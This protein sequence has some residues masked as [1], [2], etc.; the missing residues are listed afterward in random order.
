MEDVRNKGLRGATSTKTQFANF[1]RTQPGYYGEM[2]SGI[3]LQTLYDLFPVDTF[4]IKPIPP[5]DFIQRVLLPEVAVRLITEDMQA[6]AEDA[7]LTLR[8]SARYGAAMF[9][10][11]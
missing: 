1:E 5:H 9:P 2:G 11:D 7:L 6:S 3:I 10:H 8:S 4:N